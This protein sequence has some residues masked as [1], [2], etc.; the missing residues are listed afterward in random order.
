M[1]YFLLIQC[2]LF[3]SVCSWAQI[4][5]T[6]RTKKLKKVTVTEKRDSLN[7]HKTKSAVNDFMVFEG[8]K[9]EIVLMENLV[10]NK[11]ANNAR[12]IYGTVTGLNIW[13][14]DYAGLQLDIGGRGL[15]PSRSS[16]FNTRQNGYDISADALGY[17]ESYYTPPADALSEIEITRGAAALQYG[18]QFGGAVN[19]K[20]R[21]ANAEKKIAYR[22][23]QSLGSYQYI[24]SYN[25]LSGTFKNGLSYLAFYQKRKGNGWRENSSLDANNYFM[26]LEYKKSRFQLG[27][28]FT[29]LDYVAQQAGGLT[30]ALFTKDARQS[31]R[32]RNWFSVQWNLLS[33]AATYKFTSSFKANVRT[34]GLV[35]GRKSLG[36]LDRIN[37]QDLGQNRLLIDGEFKNV[38]AEIRFHKTYNFGKNRNDLVAGARLYQGNTFSRQ[39][40]ADD[41]TDAN[42]T[43]LNN[44]YPENFEYKYPN[45]NVALFAEHIFR[46]GNLSITPG[47]RLEYINTKAQGYYR[48]QVY[49]FAGNLISDVRTNES[50]G[51]QR[52]FMIAGL[53]A[54][55]LLSESTELKANFSQN[56]RA[57]NFSDLRVQNPNFVIDSNIKDERG[58]TADI[59]LKAEKEKVFKIETT[60]FYIHY[61]NRIGQILQANVAPLFLDYR[62]R[63]NVSASRNV[64]IETFVSYNLNQLLRTKNLNCMVFGNFSF[65]RATYYNSKDKSIE[66]NLVEMVPPVVL[67]AGTK[68]QQKKWKGSVQYNYVAKHYSDASNAEYT[69]SAIEGVIPAY[70]VLDI[71]AAYKLSKNVSLEGSCTNALNETYFTRRATSYPGPGIIPASPRMFFVTVGVAF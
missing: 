55:Y 27:A 36:I 63:T 4:D 47:A 56:Y 34:F 15:N 64:G 10:A 30:D 3:F 59:S 32:A 49:D 48:Q 62:L 58:F 2:F 11:A 12:Q 29:H 35:A 70:Q 22:G 17:P 65:I 46:F 5:S 33:V 25:E 41:G 21:D 67:R 7:D 54:R 23:K 43:F 9:N 20:F 14:S 52:Q 53:G 24:S 61:S 26:R 42:F 8:K 68:L 60:L 50:I 57:I 66:G 28:E 71:S 19:F 38:G 13:E 51:R 37:V 18:T 6:S 1:K 69:S 44:D 39:G 31:V 45:Q 40:L 16:N